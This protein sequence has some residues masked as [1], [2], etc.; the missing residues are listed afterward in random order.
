M[1]WT[2]RGQGLVWVQAHSC[3]AGAGEAWRGT[4]WRCHRPPCSTPPSQSCSGSHRSRR[5]GRV[6]TF[7]RPHQS[8]S[9]RSSRGRDQS[10][11][12]QSTPLVTGDPKEPHLACI[13]YCFGFLIRYLSMSTHASEE[14]DA[15]RRCSGE[16]QTLPQK[17]TPETILN[18]L[19]LVLLSHLSLPILL[20]S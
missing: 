7:L 19:R 2:D 12:A 1:L 14:G 8:T 3:T 17:T 11:L 15:P 16:Q 18:W 5:K 13:W 6:H 10:W 4:Y 9:G 20:C